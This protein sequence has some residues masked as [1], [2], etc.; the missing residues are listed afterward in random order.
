[1]NIGSSVLGVMFGLIVLGDTVPC[2]AGLYFRSDM[3]ALVD[4]FRSDP[5]E[6][7]FFVVKRGDFALL[8]LWT[9]LFVSGFLR[10]YLGVTIYSSFS[11]LSELIAFFRFDISKCTPIEP[12][13]A[14]SLIS[15]NNTRSIF[16]LMNFKFSKIIFPGIF[17]IAFN[18]HFIF[19]HR[20][21]SLEILSKFLDTAAIFFYF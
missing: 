7:I 16:P 5:C 12:T 4:T 6:V 19:P 15:L 9:E 8:L 1:M 18:K 14:F 10:G 21:T 17:V 2:L 3:L 13:S 20:Y 11:K